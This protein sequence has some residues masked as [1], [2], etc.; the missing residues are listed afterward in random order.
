MRWRHCHLYLHL[1]SGAQAIVLIAQ[2]LG[3]AVQVGDAQ[4]TNDGLPPIKRFDLRKSDFG[5]D[6]LRDQFGRLN[7]FS[8]KHSI[9]QATVDAI[10]SQLA[11]RLR[12]IL[13]G[14]LA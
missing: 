7:D 13:Q 3:D 11:E 2:C 4:P 12:A 9:E 10:S 6:F 1:G 5:E 8:A 14:E